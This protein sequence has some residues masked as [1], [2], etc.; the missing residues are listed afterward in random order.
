MYSNGV[1]NMCVGSI[2]SMQALMRYFEHQ[3]NESPAPQF[4]AT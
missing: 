1:K 4:K 2:I 3:G